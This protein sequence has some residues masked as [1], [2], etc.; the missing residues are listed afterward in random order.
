MVDWRRGMSVE[1]FQALKPGDDI[2]FVGAP[3]IEL[4]TVERLLIESGHVILTDRLTPLDRR[5][6]Q[7]WNQEVQGELL[8]EFKQGAWYFCPR[9]KEALE[10]LKEQDV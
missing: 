10:K 6:F 3:M 7:P 9:I 5:N 4:C 2:V 8:E 1:A